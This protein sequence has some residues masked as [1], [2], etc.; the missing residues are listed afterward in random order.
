RRNAHG[1]VRPRRGVRRGGGRL[2]EVLGSPCRLRSAGGGARP[3]LEA[4]GRAAVGGPARGGEPDVRAAGDPRMARG[5]AVKDAAPPAPPARA[6]TGI[7][8]EI[9]REALPYIRRFKGK[10]FVLKISGKVTENRDNLSS[11]A[12]EIA[13]LH[14]VG[15]RVTLVHG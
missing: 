8:A 13:L 6:L 4:Q 5:G 10:T 15:I 11:L 1:D 14:Q 9:L 12:E 7:D 2:C 3:P